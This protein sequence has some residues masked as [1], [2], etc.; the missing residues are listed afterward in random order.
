MPSKPDPLAL[1]PAPSIAELPSSPLSASLPALQKRVAVLRDFHKRLAEAS[2]GASYEAA[3]ARLAV[4]YW[5]TTVT[6][7]KLLAEGKLPRLPA[8]SQAAAD[9]SYFDTTAKLCEGLEKTVQSYQKSENPQK[10]HIW[11]LWNQSGKG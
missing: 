10:Q 7:L 9:K 5:A 4:A 11:R 3:H 1:A 2:L 8:V 6:R